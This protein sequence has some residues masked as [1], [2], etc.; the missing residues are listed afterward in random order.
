MATFTGTA[1]DDTLTGTSA[2]D[3]FDLR[4]GGNDTAS[5]LGG[6]DLFVFG[7]TFTAADSIDGGDGNDVLRL[8]GDYSAGVTF[9]ASTM[10]S[11]ET[12][13]VNA[14][15]DYTLT[16]VDANVAPTGTLTVTAST[17]GVNDVLSLD[18]SGLTSG[19]LVSVT[20]GD[21]NDVLLGGSGNDRFN[22]SEGGNDTV[23]AGAGDDTINMGGT[24]THSDRIDGGD[25]NDTLSLNGDYSTLTTLNN[26]T[27]TF[28]ETMK[29]GAGHDYDLALAPGNVAPHRAMTVD[30]SAL[31]TG[32][33]MTIDFRAGIDGALTVIG[34]AGDDTVM[35]GSS[36]P[37]APAIV[38]FREGG[39]DTYVAASFATLL[40]GGTFNA[41]DHVQGTP[42]GSNTT[43]IDLNGDYTGA[44]AIALTNTTLTGWGLQMRLDAGHSYHITLGSM[45][46]PFAVFSDTGVGDTATVD[47][48]ATLGELGFTGGQGSDTFIGGSGGSFF[49]DT[50]GTE[51]FK[52][53]GGSDIFQMGSH[54]TAADSVDGG[55]GADTLQVS[56]GG[57]TL[58]F[59]ATTM[60]NVETLQFQT[61]SGGTFDY[62]TNDAT[63]A[64]GATLI[65]DATLISNSGTLTFDGSA[66]TDGHFSFIDRQGSVGTDNYIGGALSDTFN[67]AHEI[68]VNA[69]GGGGADTF[70]AAAVSAHSA[71]TFIYNAVSDSTS[72]G[73]DTIKKL[74]FTGDFLKVS[75]IGAVAGIDAAV[76]SGTLSTAT[77]DSDLSAAVST[78]AAH[79]AVLFT[80]TAGTLSGHSFLVVDENGTTGYQSGGDLVMDVTGATGTLAVSSFT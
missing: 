46:V 42:A 70:T 18:A 40:F 72:T 24:L 15:N 22:M 54:F 61:G 55:A 71:D 35:G 47:A 8:D 64:A 56:G 39:N 10:T 60:I 52:G 58:V 17:L 29:L 37:T 49:T 36:S 19:G 57:T 32:D 20:A 26:T 7:G 67:L 73:Y 43:T 23:R 30:G 51:T 80:A 59:A 2:A 79:H 16:L 41:N 33:S 12:I 38:D 21:G 9:T 62:V 27:I 78:L 50:G 76:T 25:G 66:E 77:F 13:Q 63:V 31:G 53:G 28:I 6:N 69:T 4:Q 5:G 68:F 65:V 74:N 44:N 45:S 11:V 3:T 1:G 14:G 48:S 34:G 75:P